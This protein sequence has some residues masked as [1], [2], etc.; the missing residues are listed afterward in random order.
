MSG[1][2]KITSVGGKTY[3]LVFTG[4]ARI[5]KAKKKCRKLGAHLPLPT[6]DTTSRK[7]SQVSDQLRAPYHV[8]IDVNDIE[9]EGKYV[10]SENKEPQ[11]T[12]WAS[13]QPTGTKFTGYAENW[14]SMNPN[15]GEWSDQP[16]NFLASIICMQRAQEGS[17]KVFTQG[18]VRHDN[19]QLWPEWK[20][21]MLAWIK[22]RKVNDIQPIYRD[23]ARWYS[24][25]KV[26]E[27]DADYKPALFRN[28]TRL[29]ERQPPGTTLYLDPNKEIQIIDI[30][31]CA[32]NCD[33]INKRVYTASFPLPEQCTDQSDM[34][35][36]ELQQVQISEFEF[37][38]EVIVDSLTVFHYYKQER[39][40]K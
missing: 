6:D 17:S 33:G 27:F 19:L 35:K 2:K 23:V 39:K 38:L 20:V 8:A 31:K 21:T 10:T 12:N 5:W 32:A 18:D 3:C 14:V 40:Y 1:N 15:V 4:N 26:T 30:D 34:C 36:I 29:L 25:I 37:V 7:I 28:Q 9:E 22:P 11:W 24:I 13:Q 16:Q